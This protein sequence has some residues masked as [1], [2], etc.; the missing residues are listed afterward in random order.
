[1]S[2]QGGR[3]QTGFCGTLEVRRNPA[4]DAIA[5]W[6][7]ISPEGVSGNYVGMLVSAVA[8]SEE[9]LN[10][11]VEFLKT[12]DEDKLRVAEE[13]AGDLAEDMKAE[14]FALLLERMYTAGI[15][16]RNGT[17]ILRVH[18]RPD[19]IEK[20]NPKCQVLVLSWVGES[21]ILSNDLERNRKILKSFIDSKNSEIS[22]AAETAALRGVQRA[23]EKAN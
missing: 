7:R 3:Y 8:R 14:R 21:G 5:G 13:V 22:S 11:V 20:L 6:Y 15:G 2:A 1:M 17:R 19:V 16:V 18:W 4:I 10:R 9:G 23:K 12:D